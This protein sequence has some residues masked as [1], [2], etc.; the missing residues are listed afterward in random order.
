MV[1]AEYKIL[2]KFVRFQYRP[3]ARQVHWFYDANTFPHRSR[4]PASLASTLSLHDP[5]MPCSGTS[6]LSAIA[7]CPLR[8]GY[9]PRASVRS[10]AG[11]AVFGPKAILESL[12]EL[13]LS[14]RE[15][16]SMYFYSKKLAY[17]AIP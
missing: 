7:F 2:S 17:K 10:A 4:A 9:I 5:S 6:P 15:K 3:L 16:L 13:S 1:A 14:L 12:L 8:P 11:A